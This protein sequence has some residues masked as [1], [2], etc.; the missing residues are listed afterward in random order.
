MNER[1]WK[2]LYKYIFCSETKQIIPHKLD[3]LVYIFDERLH[4]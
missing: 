4:F 1:N 3:K 2:I